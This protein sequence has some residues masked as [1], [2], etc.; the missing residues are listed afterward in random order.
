[1]SPEARFDRVLDSFAWVEYFRGTEAGRAVP[2]V[3]P[4]GRILSMRHGL[5]RSVRIDSNAAAR[6]AMNVTCA[7]EGALRPVPGQEPVPPGGPGPAPSP[8]G[9]GPSS[10]SLRLVARRAD[11][12]RPPRAQIDV[13]NG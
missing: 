10:A 7:S 4:A 2:G 11:A 13:E 9:S 8:D 3:R 1:M 5:G 12:A 6:K